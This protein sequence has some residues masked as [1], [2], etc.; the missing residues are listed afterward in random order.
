MPAEAMASRRQGLDLL[1]HH[2]A[3]A[4]HDRQ[5]AQRLGQVAAGLL[6][7]GDDDGEE[8]QLRRRHALVHLAPAPGRGSGPRRGSRPGAGTRAPSGLGR[9]AG[10][11]LEAVVDRQARLDAA[12]DDVDGVGEV[13]GELLASAACRGSRRPSA[14]GPGRRRRP[15]P[16]ADQRRSGRTAAAAAKATTPSTPLMIQ[17]VVTLIVRPACCSLARQADARPC[18]AARSGS[19]SCCMICLRRASG[20]LAAA[21]RL[22]RAALF[23]LGPPKALGALDGACRWSRRRRRRPSPGRRW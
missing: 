9:L 8:A 20:V 21:A 14:A 19:C 6:L 10:D 16:S 7:D 23:C 22:A 11:D 12:H 5:V 4:Q 17:K 2:L 3:R 15:A 18:A 13:A 1:A